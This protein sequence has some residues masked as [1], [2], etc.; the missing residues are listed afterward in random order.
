EAL[1]A[2]HDRMLAL[3]R[4]H[5]ARGN[6]YFPLGQFERC[7]AEHEAALRFARLAES[8][9][10]EA[11]AL[12]GI[13][14]ALYVGGRLRQ[15]HDYVD[16]CVTLCRTHGLQAI[17]IAYLP[18]RAATHMY[19]L[20]F[21]QALDDCRSVIDLAE[22]VGQPRAE[23]VSRNTSSWVLVDQHEFALAEEHARRGVE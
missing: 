21:E 7:F 14:D 2:E 20:Q 4:I 13:C 10:E 22:K 6:I 1:A 11:R 15:A 16:R 9:E 8:T 17:E 18:M 19:G 5:H 3:S 12:G 23:V